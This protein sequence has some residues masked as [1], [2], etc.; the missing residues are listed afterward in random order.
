VLSFLQEKIWHALVNIIKSEIA[1]LELHKLGSVCVCRVVSHQLPHI[2][3]AWV[4]FQDTMWDL[5][6]TVWL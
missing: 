2:T 1:E 3:E 5:W 4:W 6:W